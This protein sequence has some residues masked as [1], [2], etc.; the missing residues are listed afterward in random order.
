[1]RSITSFFGRSSE[2]P[3]QQQ[4]QQ[5]GVKRERSDESSVVLVRDSSLEG[6]RGRAEQQQEQAK[7]ARKQQ[8]QQQRA[9]HRFEFAEPNAL[10]DACGRAPSHPDY[11]KR[12]VLVPQHLYLQ[13]TP[14]ERQFWDIKRHLFDAVVFMRKGIFYELFEK[15]ARIAHEHFGLAYSKRASMVL[16]GIPASQFEEKAAV[17]LSK[18]FRVARVDQAES[19]LAVEKRVQAGG[20][21]ALQSEDTVIRRV[22]T[23][24]LTPGTLVNPDLMVGTTSGQAPRFVA[25][26]QGERAFGL[27]IVEA[28]T[29]RIAFGNFQDDARLSL[30]ETL[31]LRAAP[32]EA[33]LCRAGLSRDA[34]S[35]VQSRITNR[36]LVH[37]FDRGEDFWDPDRARQKLEAA[38]GLE[39]FPPFVAHCGE[40]AYAALGGAFAFLHNVGLLDAVLR[41]AKLLSLE[42]DVGVDRLAVDG[43]T[44]LSLQVLEGP[45]SLLSMLDHTSTSAGARLLRAWV[46]SPLANAVQ[47]RER[48]AAV[49]QLRANEAWRV[50]LQKELSGFADVERIVTLCASGTCSVPKLIKLAT[51]TRSMWRALTKRLRCNSAFLEETLFRTDYMDDINDEK[52][53]EEAGRLGAAWHADLTENMWSLADWDELLRTKSEQID[54]PPGKFEDADK[55]R[56]E[57]AEVKTALDRLLDKAREDF[58]TRDV[59]FVDLH[60]TRY[61]FDVPSAFKSRGATA[62][63]KSHSSTKSRERF[64]H[65]VTEGLTEQ[66]RDLDDRIQVCRQ[67]Y[68]TQLQAQMALAA[69]SVAQLAACVARID[70]LLSLAVFSLAHGPQLCRPEVIER[71]ECEGRAMFDANELRH[72][73]SLRSGQ[74]MAGSD[75]SLGGK[76]ASTL[77]VTG[78]NMGGKS[79][80]LRAVCSAALLAQCGA[81]VPARS[82]RMSVCDAVFA[83]LEARDDICRGRST[84]FAEL[85][86]A[87]SVLRDATRHS[88]VVIDELGRGT[89]TADGTAVAYAVLKELV[90]RGCRLLFS[91]HFHELAAD[92]ATW[93]WCGAT[94]MRVMHHGDKLV[95]LYQLEGGV[96]PSSYGMQVARMAGIPD[97]VVG[98]ATDV[99]ADMQ[100]LGNALDAVLLKRVWKQ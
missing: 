27:C 35:M 73:L 49:D 67:R 84:L 48:L 45:V 12:S 25:F 72:P 52:A 4:Q 59:K 80:L 44:L 77:V 16:C 43:A 11:D 28:A 70:C 38:I 60:N 66:L 2:S 94:R 46:A 91:T 74:Q 58:G 56:F 61:I 34:K 86:Q 99:A 57:E 9:Q 15:D 42:E 96:T 13:M 36:A 22:V 8:Q 92:A 63:Y 39:K 24:V 54:P 64:T 71:D 7:A 32:Q 88:L 98:R 1:M 79:T 29:H 14:L 83:R 65:R 93:P 97:H 10:R 78:P 23:E 76:N 53:L 37:V 89:S 31:L 95:M 21:S 26:W 50:R 5:Q 85:L 41:G 6:I 47:I 81:W 75:V 20:R 40:E 62:G 87:S 55:C 17:L 82:L 19:S 51:T 68:L 90:D 69:E 18:G 30:L 3:Q 100:Q 33:V